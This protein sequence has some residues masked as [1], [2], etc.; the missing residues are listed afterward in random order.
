MAKYSKNSLKELGTC[1]IRIQNIFHKVIKVWDCTILEGHR[2]KEQQ[3]K[4]YKTGRSQ[5]QYPNSKHN[6][7]PSIAIDV[8][9]YPIDWNDWKRFYH[10]AGI[11][12]GIAHQMGIKLRWG[13]NWDSD[14][15]LKDNNFNDLVHFEIDE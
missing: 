8:A 2:T 14:F 7:F 13:G 11:V 5:V 10:F 6:I 1:D 4:A 9:P 12:I 15:S 3:E